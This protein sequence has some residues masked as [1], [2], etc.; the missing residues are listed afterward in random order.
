MANE[1]TIAYR[2]ATI[3]VFTGQGASSLQLGGP[4]DR[5]SSQGTGSAANYRHEVNRGV[6]IDNKVFAWHGSR[7]YKFDSSAYYAPVSGYSTTQAAFH[8]YSAGD[9]WTASPSGATGTFLEDGVSTDTFV[10]VLVSS[11]TLTLN[12][13]I[14][15]TASGE[16]ANVDAT[17]TQ[18]GSAGKEGEWGAVHVLAAALASNLAHSG[19]Y[20]M[21]VSGAM[22]LV[23][24][25]LDS[26]FAYRRLLYNP[27]TDAW[28]ESAALATAPNSADEIGKCAVAGDTLVGRIIGSSA[29]ATLARTAYSFQLNP[30]TDALTAVSKLWGSPSTG[31]GGQWRAMGAGICEFYGRIFTVM[32]HNDNS[33]RF[34]AVAELSGSSWTVVW[35]TQD[36]GA[37]PGI[38]VPVDSDDGGFNRIHAGGSPLWVADDAMYFFIMGAQTTPSTNLGWWLVRVKIDSGG[39]VY[40]DVAPTSTLG[41]TAGLRFSQHLLPSSLAINTATLAGNHKARW[42]QATDNQVNDPDGQPSFTL[43]HISDAAASGS[44]PYSWSGMETLSDVTYTWNGTTTVTISGA[45][46]VA[47]GQW[48]AIGRQGDLF[49][50][51]AVNAGVDFTI[52]NPF[53]LTIPSGTGCARMSQFAAQAAG[54]TGQRATAQEAHGGGHRQFLPGELD[55]RIV[56]VVATAGGQEITYRAVGGGACKVSFFHDTTEGSS[57]SDT[58]CSLDNPSVG[59]VV[60]DEVTGITA[61]GANRTVRWRIADDGVAV[62]T[63]RYLTPKIEAA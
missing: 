54:T 2:E 52:D 22:R 45:S 34:F 6:Q 20:A 57:L 15:V 63:R 23:G 41:Q 10:K 11:G 26:A 49:R 31:N 13:T 55:V 44:A 61:D 25:Y 48:V 4:L 56:S 50:V 42:Q 1:L 40:S 9:A 39:T 59:T 51:T 27:D 5:E 36:N 28:S 43:S 60:A 24:I 3:A 29:N 58:L 14:T 8:A 30:A 18:R 12:D 21:P 47:V 7:I 46:S 32:A 16:T 38:P 33:Q 53:G 35:S 37:N 62:N 19:L 17:Q